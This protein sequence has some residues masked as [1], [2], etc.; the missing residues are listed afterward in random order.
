MPVRPSVRHVP[1]FYGNGL[2]YCHSFFTTRQ[3]NH[4]NFMSIKHIREIPMGLPPAGSLVYKSNIKISRFSTVSRYI[5]QTILD[6][7]IYS[8]RGRRI[9]NYTQAFEWYQFQ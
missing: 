8:Y 9:R 7:A 3:P 2:T 6:S 1:V 4:S 5:S